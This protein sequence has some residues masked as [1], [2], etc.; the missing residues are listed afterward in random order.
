M[1]KDHVINHIEYTNGKGETSE[2]RVIPTYVPKKNVKAINVSHLSE[3]Q[4][5]GFV[6]LVTE[7]QEYIK[8]QQ[9]NMF[10][11]EDWIDQSY[12]EEILESEIKWV[13]LNPEKTTF[14]SE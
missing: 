7:Y 14:L 3:E 4:Q 9:A 10:S 2:K 13:T 12:G 1:F 11:F 6:V 5:A 8:Q